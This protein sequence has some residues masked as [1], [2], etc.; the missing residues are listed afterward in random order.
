MFTNADQQTRASI[1]AD[2]SLRL[3][4]P[5]ALEVRFSV[6]ERSIGRITS[7]RSPRV[8]R[9]FLEVIS[10]PDEFWLL[11]FLVVEVEP[12]PTPGLFEVLAPV[13]LVSFS[14]LPIIKTSFLSVTILLQLFCSARVTMHNE[15]KFGESPN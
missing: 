3:P 7:S 15:T 4:R 6:L 12:V 2:Q 13:F 5:S 11:A 14:L 10:R 9:S 8:L 1:N